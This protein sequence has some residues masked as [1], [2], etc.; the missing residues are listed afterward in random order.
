MLGLSAELGLPKDTVLN[1]DLNTAVALPPIPGSERTSPSLRE[2][3]GTEPTFAESLLRSRQQ[4]YASAFGRED[5]SGLDQA[6]KARKTAEDFVAI[7][8]IQ[9]M[10]KE[11]RSSSNAPPPFGAGPAE[12]Q[13][14][15]IADAQFARDLVKAKRFAL[16]DS[17][18]QRLM[19]HTPA[20]PAIPELS[21]LAGIGPGI[22]NAQRVSLRGAQ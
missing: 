16:V 8:F 12:K 15:Q 1:L 3:L 4:G 19:L 11:F 20:D 9:P 14:R 7:A 13:F 5:L 2:Q 22:A 21:S 18:A 17:I 6:A 10:L